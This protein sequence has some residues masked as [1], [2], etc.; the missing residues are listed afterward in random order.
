MAAIGSAQ[1]KNPT[2]G[3]AIYIYKKKSNHQII[4]TPRC[5][6]CGHLELIIWVR[7]YGQ[8]VCRYTN[9]VALCDGAVLML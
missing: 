9:V 5:L 1:V 4:L 7:G 6:A 2:S 3:N 8:F